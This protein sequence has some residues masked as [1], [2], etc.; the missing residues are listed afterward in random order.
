MRT[1]TLTINVDNAAF[2]GGNLYPEVA[3]LLEET[4]KRVRHLGLNEATI[5]DTNGNTVGQFVF[6][7]ADDAPPT[8]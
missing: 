4:A 6:S 1:F 2:E 3:Y 5:S 8:E 7:E